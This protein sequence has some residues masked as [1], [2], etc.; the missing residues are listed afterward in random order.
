MDWDFDC[1][2]EGDGGGVGRLMVLI[3]VFIDMDDEDGLVLGL[4]LMLL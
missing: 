3:D 1:F 2:L 4:L